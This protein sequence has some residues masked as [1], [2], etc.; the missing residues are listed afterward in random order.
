MKKKLGLIIFTV[1]GLTACQQKNYQEL[2]GEW[3]WTIDPE[4]VLDTLDWE[5]DFELGIESITI[6]TDSGIVV[7]EYRGDSL[8]NIREFTKVRVAEFSFD[9]ETHGVLSQY[10]L[11]TLNTV[12][13]E[14]PRY[15]AQNN[16][17]WIFESN[18]KSMIVFDYHFNQYGRVTD[19][20]EFQI[21]NGDLLIRDDTLKRLTIP[22]SR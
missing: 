5:H 17:F 20:L 11:D 14:D 6:N 12:R 21:L 9:D 16:N 7:T 3:Y 10:D 1:F 8:I 13:T 4:Y 15:T 19:T 18:N 22:N 2:E